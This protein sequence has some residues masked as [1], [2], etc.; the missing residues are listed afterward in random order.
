[1]QWAIAGVGSGALLLLAESVAGQAAWAQASAQPLAGGPALTVS[2]TAVVA[3]GMSP[4]GE[5]VW[6][7]MTRKVEAYEAIYVRRHG[8]VQA[9]AKGQAQLP[10]TEAITRQSI[11]VAVDLAT[12]AWATASPAGFVPLAFELP[13][14]ALEVRGGALADRLIDAADY[15]EVLLVRPGKGAWG[16]S[17]GRGGADDESAA[18]EAV[19]R[20]SLDKLLPLPGTLVPSPGKLNSKDVI[21]VLH[22]RAMAIA[23]VTFGGKP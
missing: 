19:F 15:G 16:T 11:W 13:A 3:T 2:A 14:E 21:F 20:L 7:A 23:A 8:T 10:V 9:D 18:G 4:G 22:P 12:G 6:L 5:V 17:I 1:M